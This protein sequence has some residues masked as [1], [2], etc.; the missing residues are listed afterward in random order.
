MEVQQA[1]INQAQAQMLKKYLM[2][3]NLFKKKEEVI[4]HFSEGQRLH[5]ADLS[6]DEAVRCI[7]Y[8]QELEVRCQ[9]MRRKMLSIGYEMYFDEPLT[10]AQ[11]A[12]EPKDVN[13]KNVNAWC[14]SEK[15][16]YRKPLK[17][18]DPFE[19]EEVVTQFKMVRDNTAKRR[20]RR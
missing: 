13:F 11:R 14:E 17:R 16:K 5:I 10:P 7:N 9:N 4:S 12:M 8:L 3:T 15:C 19:L 6:G 1:P 20:Q 2:K 18:L